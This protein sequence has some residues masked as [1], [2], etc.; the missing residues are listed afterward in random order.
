MAINTFTLGS[1]GD[2]ANLGAWSTARRT[3]SSSGDTER[4][5][6]LAGAYTTELTATLSGWT[7]G[8]IAEI[9]AQD[10]PGT[11]TVSG[12]TA[13]ITCNSTWPTDLLID[14]VDFDLGTMNGFASAIIFSGTQVTDHSATIRNCSGHGCVQASGTYGIRVAQSMGGGAFSLTVDNMLWWGNVAAHDEFSLSPELGDFTLLVRSSTIDGDRI[15]MGSSGKA[16]PLTYSLTFE[17]CLMRTVTLAATGDATYTRTMVDCIAS[18]ADPSWG[19]QTNCTFGVTFNNSGAPASGEVSWTDATAGDYTLVE[20]ANNLAIDYCD[21]ATPIATDYAGVARVGT[22]DAGAYESQYGASTGAMEVSWNMGGVRYFGGTF[23]FINFCRRMSPFVSQLSVSPWT[24]DDGRAIDLDADGYP[25]TLLTNQHLVTQIVSVSS[26]DG[27]AGNYVLRFGGA[28]TFN[29]SNVTSLT[30][31]S[32]GRWTFTWDGVS[33]IA[34][35]IT[36]ISSPITSLELLLVDNETEYDGGA[37]FNPTFLAQLAG[38]PMV[39]CMDWLQTNDS[40]NTSSHTPLSYVSWGSTS[41]VPVDVC[42]DLANE[43]GADLWYCFPHQGT[44]AL[45]TAVAAKL[46]DCTG[47]VYVEYSN[48]IWNSIFDQTTYCQDQGVLRGLGGGDI[49]NGA[50]EFLIERSMEIWDLMNTAGLTAGAKMK[51]VLAGQASNDYGFNRMMTHNSSAAVGVVDIHSI[52]PYFGRAVPSTASAWVQTRTT[53][54]YFGSYVAS[55]STT[56]SGV[57]TDLTTALQYVQDHIDLGYGLPI[58]LYEGGQ[59]YQAAVSSDA[60]L[61]AYLGSKQNLPE[62]GLA[63]TA[64]L[65]GLEAKGVAGIAVYS[66]DQAWAKQA[67]YGYW[68]ALPGGTYTAEPYSQWVKWQAVQD[69]IGGSIRMYADVGSFSTTFLNASLVSSDAPVGGIAQ[70]LSIGIGIGI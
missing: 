23:P 40:P 60:A 62:M 54:E 50:R 64:Y 33:N 16:T 65:E 29:L 47:N 38:V 5:E 12:F 32:A 8:V 6:I 28:M 11:V 35:T 9:V 51:R 44:D 58:Y 61:V 36:S 17:C 3:A 43:L 59:H 45:A 49:Y 66:L 63:Y 68:G 14:G 46:M 26:A 42:V 10:G 69:Y 18:F 4:L 22:A 39:R 30:E 2:Y 31:A 20:D 52:A 19:T 15:N 56:V 21:N 27:E 48:E 37:L 24:Y 55:D 70:R 34:L 67:Q 13:G 1:G 41:G 7:Q 57:A 25:Q 53:E